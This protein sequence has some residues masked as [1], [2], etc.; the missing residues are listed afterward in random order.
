MMMKNNRYY[1]AS[2]IIHSKG[3]SGE[4][5]ARARIIFTVGAWL[6]QA[7]IFAA[8]GAALLWAALDGLDRQIAIDKAVK[9]ER[10]AK[11]GESVIGSPLES[12]CADLG[13]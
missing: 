2:M 10:C 12:Y 6:V 13:V 3:S 8:M 1:N 9:A 4:T 5:P 7:L 11:L